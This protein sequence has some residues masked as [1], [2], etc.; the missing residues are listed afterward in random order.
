M[1]TKAAPALVVPADGAAIKP[2]I[3]LMPGG[4][5]ATGIRCI[6]TLESGETWDGNLDE[7][8]MTISQ[9]TPTKILQALRDI[10]NH[11]VSTLG[12]T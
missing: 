11:A 12:Y 4:G 2:S 5:G 3:H 7:V 9:A 10:R 1:P 6:I 8:P